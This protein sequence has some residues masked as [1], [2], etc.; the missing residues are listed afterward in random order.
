MKRFYFTCPMCSKT[1]MSGID[2]YENRTLQCS[3]GNQLH[4]NLDELVLVQCNSCEKNNA[5]PRRSGKSQCCLA[6]GHIL[7]VAFPEEIL[8]GDDKR[9]FD[10]MIESLNKGLMTKVKVDKANKLFQQISKNNQLAGY[11]NHLNNY[12]EFIMYDS[13]YNSAVRAMNEAEKKLE[14]ALQFKSE[15]EL[16]ALE[17]AFSDAANRFAMMGSF[18]Q[19]VQHKQNCEKQSGRCHYEKE[20]L[21]APAAAQPA[22][23]SPAA[24]ARSG[25]SPSRPRQPKKQPAAPSYIPKQS[26]I[27][28]GMLV[29]II[30]GVGVLAGIIAIVIGSSEPAE[31]PVSVSSVPDSTSAASESSVIPKGDGSEQDMMYQEFARLMQEENYDI[32]S[33]NLY[34][35]NLKGYQ[36]SDSI[37]ESHKDGFYEKF[38]AT[39]DHYQ[40]VTEFDIMPTLE[41]LEGLSYFRGYRETD[42]LLNKTFDKNIGFAEQLAGMGDNAQAA[43]VLLALADYLEEYSD[44]DKLREQIY[45]TAQALSSSDAVRAGELLDFIPDYKDA[46]ALKAALG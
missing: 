10:Q 31:P 35:D 4:V 23:A 19:S 18:K 27:N 28:K 5:L 22:A 13:E 21:D 24:P 6:C 7:Q 29:G 46:A 16:S 43:S 36:D 9:L 40:D 14:K 30:V 45:Q 26:R 41:I 44:Q 11:A 20:H 1:V 3:C 42:D 8:D 32:Y 37:F 33:I 39:A 17:K 38:K 2:I 15:E 25:T 12:T 34:M